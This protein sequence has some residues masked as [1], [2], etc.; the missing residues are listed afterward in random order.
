MGKEDAVQKSLLPISDNAPSPVWMSRGRCVYSNSAHDY[1]ILP[2][3]VALFWDQGGRGIAQSKPL[4]M[5][6]TILTHCLNTTDINNYFLRAQGRRFCLGAT[7]KGPSALA[8]L[9]YYS[10]APD[11]GCNPRLSAD[12]IPKTCHRP[13]FA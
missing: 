4:S 10:G 11:G 6:F 8:P 7:L 13:L 1:A 12:V 2:I 3:A 5:I 9:D